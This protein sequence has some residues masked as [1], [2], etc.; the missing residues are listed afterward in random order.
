MLVH[1][2][3]Q[4]LS[5]HPV[6]LQLLHPLLVL[7]QGLLQ[8]GLVHTPALLLLLRVVQLEKTSEAFNPSVLLRC[9]AGLGRTFI[10]Y[11]HQI[12]IEKSHLSFQLLDLSLGHGVLYLELHGE[13]RF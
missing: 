6:A 13:D 12:L 7:L 8:L 5:L 9:P 1:R 11:N 3:A 4:A 10:R 2:L